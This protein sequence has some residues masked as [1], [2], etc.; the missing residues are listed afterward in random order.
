MARERPRTPN[1][2]PAEMEREMIPGGFNNE[3]SI[4]TN[5]ILG[6][7]KAFWIGQSLFLLDGIARRRSAIS[8]RTMQVKM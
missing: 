7:V 4:R 5:M 6:Q 2:I 3:K 1:V 8:K